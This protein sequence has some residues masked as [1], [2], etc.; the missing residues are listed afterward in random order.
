[1]LAVGQ[2]RL[3]N[4][5]L[6][7]SLCPSQLLKRAAKRRKNHGKNSAN[8][9]GHVK[10][11]RERTDQNKDEATD[12]AAECRLFLGKALESLVDL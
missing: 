2:I 11:E 5:K 7:F 6:P 4:Q 12:T 1:M 3:S 9:K 10:S 8:T